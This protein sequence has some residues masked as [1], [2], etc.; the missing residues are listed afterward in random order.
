MSVLD[1]VTTSSKKVKIVVVYFGTGWSQGRG[2]NF[3]DTRCVSSSDRQS[4]EVA[5]RVV[6]CA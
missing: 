1:A 6:H 4:N 2:E 5:Y 3:P